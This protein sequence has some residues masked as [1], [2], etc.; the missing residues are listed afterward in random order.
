VGFLARAG[1][2]DALA[3]AL[4]RALLDRTARAAMAERQ[5]ALCLQRFDYRVVASRHL[6]V[7]EQVLHA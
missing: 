1:D 6:A 5:R 3:A 7:Y 4:E 2:A